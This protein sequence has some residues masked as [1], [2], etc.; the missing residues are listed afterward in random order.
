MIHLLTQ[1]FLCQ[2]WIQVDGDLKYILL[3]E[4]DYKMDNQETKSFCSLESTETGIMFV[5]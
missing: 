5:F 2:V 3:N 4:D 1:Q